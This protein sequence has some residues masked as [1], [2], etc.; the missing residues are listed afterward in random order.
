MNKIGTASV[1]INKLMDLNKSIGSGKVDNDEKKGES[2]GELLSKSVEKVNET[3]TESET[4]MKKYLS[5]N[6]G[7]IHETMISLEK[8]DI[9][10]RLMVQVR[11]KAVEAYREI[12]R[13]Q[14]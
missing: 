14:V 2:F 9:S 4:E 13:M 3:Q 5:G 8:A 6:G 7:G 11:N 10:L 1:N 12:M